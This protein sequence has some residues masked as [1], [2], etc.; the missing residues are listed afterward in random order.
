MRPLRA[1][2]FLGCVY[3]GGDVALKDWG[4]LQA[5]VEATAAETRKERT[6]EGTK[7]KEEYPRAV[8]LQG[9]GVSFPVGVDAGA[10]AWQGRPLVEAVALMDSMATG[11]VYAEVLKA[12]V[13]TRKLALTARARLIKSM[14]VPVAVQRMSAGREA[15]G[16][17]GGGC[18]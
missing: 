13:A 11:S 6:A 8:F 2:R 1:A 10:M 7:L 18:G 4:A 16:A 15:T 14:V 9:T 5:V 12:N 3:R 17:T